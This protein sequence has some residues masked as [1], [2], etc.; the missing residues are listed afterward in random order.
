[1]LVPKAFAH[2]RKFADAVERVEQKLRGEVIRIRHALDYDS[3]L[4]A[5]QA[6]GRPLQPLPEQRKAVEAWLGRQPLS[7][8]D[9]Q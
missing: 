4:K 3:A 2:Q 5:I 9:P 8:D 7:G 1:M 6:S